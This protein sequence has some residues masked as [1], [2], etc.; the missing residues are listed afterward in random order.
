M[1]KYL[2]AQPRDFLAVATPGAG[3]T[4]FALTL[5]SWLLHHHVVQQVTV[6]APTEHLKKQW[7]EAAAR[8]GIKLDPEYSAGPSAGSTTASPSRTPVSACAPCC[9]ATVSSSARR[10]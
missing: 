6:V 3:K 2:Q 9:T 1:D 7:A 8:I 4:T 5:A 10:S